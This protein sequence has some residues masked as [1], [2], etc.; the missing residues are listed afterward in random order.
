MYQEFS[1]LPHSDR[2]PENTSIC[3]ILPDLD[4]SDTAKKDPDVDKQAREWANMLRKRHCLTGVDIAKIFTMT[5]L[6]REYSHVASR[7]KLATTY[8]IFLVDS[9]LQVKAISFLGTYFKKPGK[10]PFPVRSE[11]GNL[12]EQ[13]QKSY[14]LVNLPL[15][16]LKDSVSI[17][18]GNL[19]QTTEHLK[20]NLKTII[21]KLVK[22]CQGGAGNIR[23]CYIQTTNT[24]L[25]LPIYVDFGS[26]NDVKLVEPRKREYEEIYGECS[27]L[28]DGMAV[29]VTRDGDVKVVNVKNEEKEGK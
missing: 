6:E 8:D 11:R 13:I 14:S 26:A 1:Q 4:R 10:M 16:S 3:L 25:S 17:R 22:N 21:E 20:E 5:Q 15:E 19:D 23:T 2:N 12:A 7:Q 18:L 24:E 27:T 9:S 28:P 29:V